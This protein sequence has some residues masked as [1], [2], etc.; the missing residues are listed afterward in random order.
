MAT[1]Y[2]LWD[3][4]TLNLVAEFPSEAEA[5]T[6]L[7]ETLEYDGQDSLESL[8]LGINREDGRGKTIARGAELVALTERIV[9]ERGKSAVAT[10][11][12]A[13]QAE[14]LAPIMEEDE[15]GFATGDRSRR[16]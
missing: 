13:V 7:V 5:L 12:E 8:L 1:T 14:E 6:A 2:Q 16:R 10:R 9:A 3:T 4:D 15:E 11:P